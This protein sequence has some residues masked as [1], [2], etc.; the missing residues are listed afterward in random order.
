MS[1]S[2]IDVKPLTVRIGA[3]IRGVDLTRPL[4]NHQVSAI[5]DALIAHQ[6]IFFRGQSMDMDAH[7]R[8]GGHFGQLYDHVDV[9]GEEYISKHG[10]PGHPAIVKIHADETSTAVAAET[11]HTDMSCRVEPPMGTILHLHTLPPVG[12]DTLFASTTAAYDALSPP[13]EGLSGRA[14]GCPRW[15]PRL[16]QVHGRAQVPGHRPSGGP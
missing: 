4:S 2:P 16:R 5:H 8:F 6:V 10:T 11:W 14:D 12:G 7:E 9:F 13:D 3:E 1:N 15:R